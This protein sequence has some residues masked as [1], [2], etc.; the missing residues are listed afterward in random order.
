MKPADYRVFLALLA[1]LA[2]ALG[3]VGCGDDDGDDDDDDDDMGMVD[4][5]VD[6]GGGECS[7]EGAACEVAGDCCSGFCADLDG[8]TNGEDDPQCVSEELGTIY[9]NFQTSLHRTRT[10]KSYFYEG[11]A[12]DPGYFEQTGVEYDEL[13]C[14][15][16]HRK[17]TED[18]SKALLADGTEIELDI[19]EPTCADCHS[20]PYDPS[21]EVDSAT[22][23][24]CHGRQ[25]AEINLSNSPN[26]TISARFQDVHRDGANFDCVDCHVASQF[27]GD[28]TSP[29]SLLQVREIGCADCHNDDEGGV[30]APDPEVAEHSTHGSPG[31]GYIECAACHVKSVASCYSCHFRSEFTADHKTF[32][33]PP[34]MSGFIFLVNDAREGG[35]IGVASYQSLT[36]NDEN[37]GDGIDDLNFVAFAPFYGHTVGGAET[38]RRCADC[39]GN[40]VEPITNVADYT[41]GEDYRITTFVGTPGEAMVSDVQHRQGVIPIP[42]DYEDTFIF[43]L[44]T[45]DTISPE[46]PQYRLAEGETTFQMLP[47]FATPLT[48]DQ[49]RALGADIPE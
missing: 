11:T 37:P 49:M 24:G 27:H 31:E 1:S 33:G 30:G 18:P 12:E 28:G 44:V 39:H 2:L 15:D 48:D 4:G 3:A 5:G 38:A 9:E 34:P 45:A 26:E 29:D 17:G 14:G 35:G 21:G 20:D 41:P 19:Y 36:T 25:R 16:C 8:S 22:C 47:E 23:I 46:I 42:E 40:F 43:D 10:G 7:A 6:G 32:F 13:V